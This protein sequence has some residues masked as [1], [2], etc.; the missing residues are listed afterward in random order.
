MKHKRR[1]M[2]FIILALE[3]V[4]FTG[5]MIWGEKLAEPEA[6]Y[7]NRI[8]QERG[9]LDGSSLRRMM[10]E[11]K[12]SPAVA[13]AYIKDHPTYAYLFDNSFIEYIN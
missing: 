2:F 12:L 3:L 10:N 4:C 13:D 11:A 8:I 9:M 1:T 7:V 5:G 6:E